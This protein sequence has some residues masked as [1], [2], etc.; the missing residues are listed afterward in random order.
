M[1]VIII[2]KNKWLRLV[3]KQKKVRKK[4][5]NEENE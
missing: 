1:Y 5:R 3:K 2:G 4:R